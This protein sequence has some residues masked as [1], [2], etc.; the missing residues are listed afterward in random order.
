MKPESVIAL[1]RIAEI[2][3]QNGH[4][5]FRVAPGGDSFEVFV[6]DSGS[7]NGKVIA[8]FGPFACS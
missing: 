5:I 2:A 1:R 4:V 8:R 6:K 3:S 7:E